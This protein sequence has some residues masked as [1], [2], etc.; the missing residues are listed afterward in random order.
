MPRISFILIFVFLMG[1]GKEKSYPE[2]DSALQHTSYN[3]QKEGKLKEAVLF[4]LKM[5]KKCRQKNY[6]KGVGWAYLNVGNILSTL[7]HYKESLKY[8]ELAEKELSHTHDFYLKTKLYTDIGK[9]NHF[10][11]LYEV[12]LGF[13]NKAI[14]QCNQ[15]SAVNKRKA[16]LS[17]VYAC[18][19]DNFEFLNEQD[20][21]YI[22]FHKAYT[23]YADPITA[24][25]IANYFI[26]YRKN[27]IDS[28]KYYLDSANERL[29]N[30]TYDLFQKLVV[31]K[32]YGKFYYEKKQY[33][34]ALDFYLQSLTI[35][36]KLDKKDQRKI[37]YRLLSHTYKAQKNEKK[38][39]EYLEKYLALNESMTDENNKAVNIS[40]DHILKQQENENKSITNTG[41][42]ASI[43]I[44]MLGIVTLLTGF[45]LY[46]R[47]KEEKERLILQQK[48]EITRKDI[49]KKEL[50]LKVN[51]AFEEVV[52]LARKN[53][54][55]FLARFKQVYPEFCENLLAKYPDLL[56]SELTFCAYLK[57]NLTSKEIANYTFVTHKAIELRKNRFRKKMHIPSEENLYL[58]IDKI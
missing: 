56:N 58:W 16:A 50:E 10:L 24:A 54:P 21:M 51:D 44:S 18:K 46:S 3:F 40:V 32:Q 48:D 15:I 17:Y 49:E 33:D 9:V 52:Q 36:N 29:K 38:H 30:N 7:T 20:S 41:D 12:A 26:V 55:S 43:L 11:G 19:A 5:V 1:Y 2:I 8:L 6:T 47:K 45:L 31:L 25:N 57:L 39:A 13:Y 53:D 27:E 35:A 28:A 22:Y 14:I 34:K 42:T 37:I 23:S 4:N